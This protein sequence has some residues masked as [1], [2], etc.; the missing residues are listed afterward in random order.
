MTGV[1]LRRPRNLSQ[2]LEEL[3][4]EET[5]VLAGGQ[6]LVLLMNTGL[7]VP[8]RLVSIAELP[9]L[10][11]V[12]AGDDGLD[13]GALCTH[14]ELAE[15]PVIRERMPAVARMFDGVGNIRVRNA[16]TVGGNL[17]HADPAQDPPVMLAVLGARATV[18][19][20]A[21]ERS[22]AV[23]DVAEGPFWPALEHD[24]LLTRVH[25]PWPGE[26]DRTAYIKFL[27]G[28][29]D[30][31]ATVSVGAR[32]T[33][34]DG[35]VTSAR[36]AAGAVGP[37]VVVLDDAAEVLQGRAPDDSDAHHELGERV[38]DLVSPMPDR[39]GSADYK[40]EM[41]GV[42]ARRAVQACLSGGAATGGR[43]QAAGG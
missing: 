41:A 24:E 5:L 34:D 33:V 18:V 32:L 43:A 2:A 21:G 36:M 1:V 13:I 7:V 26:S 35:I 39:R 30:D 31:Y 20:P 22:L 19:G 11:G 3:A 23:E 25:V 38:R 6:S 27:A 14:R 40:R 17:V 37:T 16:G 9:E 10:R 15:H 4:D 12:Q 8:E 28:S 42:V 29:H